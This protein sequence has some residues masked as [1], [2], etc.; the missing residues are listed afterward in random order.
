MGDQFDALASIR[1]VQIFERIPVRRPVSLFLKGQREEKR[2]TSHIAPTN[3]SMVGT[4]R[5]G[6]ILK[7]P[8]CP[9]M[10]RIVDFD[11]RVE[12]GTIHIPREMQATVKDGNQVHVTITVE[13]TRAVSE[14]RTVKRMR[15][16][17]FEAPPDFKPL[18][19]DEIYDRAK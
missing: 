15:E 7:K 9:N 3:V 10:D 2:R 14:K 8:C 12:D 18:T 1:E 19:R 17:P 13:P 5:T 11:A 16:H 4:S 6:Q